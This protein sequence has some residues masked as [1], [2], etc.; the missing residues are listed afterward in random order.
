MGSKRAFTALFGVALFA[1]ALTANIDAFAQAASGVSAPVGTVTL[2]DAEKQSDPTGAM[3]LGAALAGRRIVAVGEHGL[4]ILSDDDGQHFRQAKKVPANSTLTSVAFIDAQHGWAVGHWGVVLQTSD[5][6]ES[7]T[8][9][10]SATTVDQPLFSVA[11]RDA[12]HGWAVG[13]WS[14]ILTTD[15]GGHTWATRT[16]D[17]AS[18]AG[19]DGLNLYGVFPGTRGTVYAVGEQGVVLK[20]TDDGVTWGATHTG[21]SGTLWTGVQADDGA[22]YVGGLRGHMFA[23]TD[24]GANWHSVDSGVMG[25]ITDLTASSAGVAGVALDGFV[26]LMRN[27]ASAFVPHR[28]KGHQALTAIVVTGSGHRV[29]F[30]KSG[31]ELDE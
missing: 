20:S 19:K 22:I 3:L 26:T 8:L 6:G 31:V 1:G 7:W 5:G 12:H 2:S 29:V 4:I 30:A 24:D 25:S 21:Y 16:L 23:S 10:R 17:K 18:G 13:L 14:L 11:F 27:G 28:L 15:D 9:Q